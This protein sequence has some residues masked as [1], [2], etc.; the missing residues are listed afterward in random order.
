MAVPPTHDKTGRARK[1][2]GSILA[3]P[4]SSTTRPYRR[5]KIAGQFAPRLIEMM[6][7]PPFRVLSLSGHRVLARIEIELAH[8]GGRDNGRLPVTFD[9]FVR[10]GVDRHAIA[11]AMREVEAL[12]FAVVTERGRAANADFRTPN[13][14]RLTYRPTQGCGATD[15]WRNIKTDEDAKARAMAARSLTSKKSKSRASINRNPVGEK[16]SFSGG[17]PHRKSQSPSGENPHYSAM[18]ETHTTLDISL[19]ERSAPEGRAVAGD[20]QP[21]IAAIMKA[22]GCDRAVAEAIYQSIPVAS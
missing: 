1:S 22:N 13:K 5:N 14:F 2:S 19:G 7:S 18:A 12:G 6:E 20:P 10:Y 3:A 17:N 21:L 11:P 9:D 15:D 4:P 8:H 16:T